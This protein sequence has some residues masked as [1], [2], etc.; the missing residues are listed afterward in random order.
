MVFL[1][2]LEQR[3]TSVTPPFSPSPLLFFAVCIRTTIVQVH[4][5]PTNIF[6]LVLVLVLVL[7]YRVFDYENEANVVAA[8]AASGPSEFICGAAPS[9]F[10]PTQPGETPAQISAPPR[11]LDATIADRQPARI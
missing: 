10:H 1:L 5:S 9:V 8:S 11:G 4:A 7:D 6:V 3:Q 2:A